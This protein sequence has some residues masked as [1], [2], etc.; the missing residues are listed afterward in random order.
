MGLMLTSRPD[1]T[2]GSTL[3]LGLLGSVITTEIP[4]S[5]E[6]QQRTYTLKTDDSVVRCYFTSVNLYLF[7]V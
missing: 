7:K 3:E 6:E 1:P 5:D 4:R 2:P